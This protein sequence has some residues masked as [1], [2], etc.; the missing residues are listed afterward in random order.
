LLAKLLL[1]VSICVVGIDKEHATLPGNHCSF[2]QVLQGM[3][4]VFGF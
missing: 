3:N 2:I 1:L 4:E